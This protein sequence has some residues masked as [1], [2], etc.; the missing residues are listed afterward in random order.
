MVAVAFSWWQEKDCL[1][2]GLQA[3]ISFLQQVLEAPASELQIKQ[4]QLEEAEARAA[5]ERE[6]REAL[7]RRLE[8]KAL[9]CED[10]AGRNQLLEAKLLLLDDRRWSLKD[11]IS[12]TASEGQHSARTEPE[13]DVIEVFIASLESPAP[14]PAAPPKLR[15]PARPVPALP[16]PTAPT[17]APQT[18]RGRLARSL[19]RKSA[20]CRS[21]G[22][23]VRV[24]ATELSL[25]A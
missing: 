16:L 1:I 9:L 5:A 2:Q 6:L 12:T 25:R 4:K 11:D 3:H 18:A 20:R 8:Q 15:N 24:L 13:E 7:Q 10:L 21:L 14:A 23:E 19:E 22:S 17:R